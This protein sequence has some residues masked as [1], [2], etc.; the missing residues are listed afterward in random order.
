MT[1]ARSRQICLDLTLNYHCTTRCVRRAFLSGDDHFTQRNFD[2]RRSWI[3]GHLLFLAEIFCIEIAAFSVQS[4]HY[5]VVLKVLRDQALRLTDDNVI[6]RW[7]RLFRG[8]DI[9]QRY[10]HGELTADT[11]LLEVAAIAASWRCSLMDISRFMAH[12][13]ESIARQANKEDHCT[14]KFWEARYQLQALLDPEPLIQSMCQVGP[15]QAH[16]SSGEAPDL[17][18]T[19]IARRLAHKPRGLKSSR[20]SLLPA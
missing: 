19:S 8:P 3:E 12:I 18:H 5:H 9:I 15:G 16:A 14:G 13:N 2:H 20:K 17:D 11:D 4:D 10:I 6:A 1:I 7:R